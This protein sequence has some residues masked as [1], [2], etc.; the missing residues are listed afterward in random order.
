MNDQTI[1]RERD[2]FIK[3]AFCRADLLFE[4]DSELA[5]TFAAGATPM[6]FSTTPDELKGQSFL[7]LIDDKHRANMED[8]LS[9]GGT[10][11]RIEDAILKVK[12]PNGVGIIAT[13]A[14]F[15]APEF[16]DHYFLALKIGPAKETYV[17]DEVA[18]EA[19]DN[20]LLAQEDFSQAAAER[21]KELGEG[22]ETGQLTML[23][24]R[25]IKDLVKD[26]GASERHG[27]TSAIGGI[28][29]SY[30]IGGNTAGQIDEENFGYVHGKD[31]DP[32]QVN[33]EI[34]DTAQEFLGGDQALE[35][36]STTLDADGAEMSEEQV[37]KA[38]VY[39]MDQFCS[40]SGK[41]SADKLSD[42]L[43][44]L[45]N[46]T[47]ESV[48]YIKS[49]AKSQGFD[50]VFMPICDL[51]LGK[52]HHFEALSRFRDPDRAKT[53]FQIITLAE[54]LGLITD[55]D[56]AV[57]DKTVK[58]LKQFAKKGPLPSV[59]INLSSL[60]L[61]DDAFVAKVHKR[62]AR[63]KWLKGKLMFE[64]TESAEIDDLE[65]MN[66]TIQ[67]FLAR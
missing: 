11:G 27:L 8:L 7:T 23:R 54:N 29:K 48:K 2:I 28:L 34:E 65:K 67:S 50:L 49:V 60:S 38:L 47:V 39:T 33:Q 58:L 42:S 31:V 66:A 43:D 56:E 41:I 17:S 1:K 37:A 61:I 10:E 24:I 19:A 6:L 12:G 45:M 4:L 40:G 16:D 57:F 21:L 15:K 18:L 59:A 51:R 9:A 14:G 35:T 63:D 32:E 25:N 53:T 55:F 44:E 3:L 26:L 36:K 22:E 5:I 62:L 64:I 52:V 13:V 30:S 20:I 46:G